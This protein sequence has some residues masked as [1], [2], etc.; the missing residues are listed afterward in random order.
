[1]GRS[2]K[3]VN[4]SNNASPSLDSEERTAKKAKSECHASDDYV[5]EESES[6]GSKYDDSTETSEEEQPDK[7]SEVQ[8]QCK[9]K[10]WKGKKNQ[11]NGL[12]S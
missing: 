11:L 6:D 8:F 10:E 3:A 1:M 5:S 12:M 9:N 7:D 4:K 2:L